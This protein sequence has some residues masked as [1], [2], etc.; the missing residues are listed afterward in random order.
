MIGWALANVSFQYSIKSFA[1]LAN[2]DGMFIDEIT[3]SG[4]PRCIESCKNVIPPA[5][6]DS[7]GRKCVIEC[8][9]ADDYIV[10][11]SELNEK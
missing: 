2:C 6:V 9:I 1:S 8:R 5:Y 11:N 4:N 3:D 7:D 10:I